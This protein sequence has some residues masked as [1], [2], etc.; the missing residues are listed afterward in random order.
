MSDKVVLMRTAHYVYLVADLMQLPESTDADASALQ[1]EGKGRRQ[2]PLTA[3]PICQ[4]PTACSK[5]R[6][7]LHYA[8]CP[9][10]QVAGPYTDAD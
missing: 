5:V 2:L 10:E 3:G 7:A 6:M 8:V 9:N 4:M 1:M